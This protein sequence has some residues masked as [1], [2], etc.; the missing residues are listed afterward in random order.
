MVQVQEE[1]LEIPKCWINLLQLFI[2]LRPQR[3]YRYCLIGALGDPGTFIKSKF[4]QKGN[5]SLVNSQG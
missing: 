5:F 1:G 4:S 3:F 2:W